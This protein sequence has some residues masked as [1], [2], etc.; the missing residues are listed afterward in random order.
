[1][2]ALDPVTRV[3]H[4]RC[5][6]RSGNCCVALI[7]NSRLHQSFREPLVNVR[8]T[9]SA[10]GLIVV[11]VDGRTAV[12]NKGSDT[13]GDFPVAISGTLVRIVEEAVVRVFFVQRWLRNCFERVINSALVGGHLASSE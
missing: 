7:L 13:A 4:W 11:A 5:S 3:V 12:V 8:P 2:R 10:V 6:P 1:M 9:S